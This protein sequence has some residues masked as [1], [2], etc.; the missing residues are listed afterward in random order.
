MIILSILVVI[1]T[2]AHAATSAIPPSAYFLLNYEDLTSPTWPSD[3]L[4]YSIFI[5]SPTHMTAE[6]VN[7]VRTDVPGA[8]VLAYFDSI[9]IPVVEGCSTG[10][11]MGNLPIQK[12]LPDDPEGF[13]KDL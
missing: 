7:K 5:A 10:S 4:Q 11:P 6:L 1:T 13:Y 9:D 8:R 2:L 3:Y 12:E